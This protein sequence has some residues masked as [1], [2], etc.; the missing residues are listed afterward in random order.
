MKAR[1]AGLAVCLAVFLPGLALRAQEPPE[2]RI[3]AAFFRSLPAYRVLLTES[4]AADS[5]EAVF[6]IAGAEHNRT[7]VLLH[8]LNSTSAG[9]TALARDLAADFRVILIDLPGYG[10]SFTHKPISYDYEHM[11][12]RLLTILRAADGL[13]GAL[14]VGHSTGGALAWHLDLTEECRPAGLVLI[15]AVTVSFKLPPVTDL[16]FLVAAGYDT[17]GPFFNLIGNPIIMDLV[18]H[19]SSADITRPLPENRDDVEPMF[20]TPARIRVNRMWARQMLKPRVVSTWEPRLAEIDSPA[21]LIWGGRDG[22]L[23]QDVMTRA[24]AAIPGARGGVIDKAGHSPQRSHPDRVAALIR[25]F[26]AGL[27]LADRPRSL[28]PDAVPADPIALAEPRPE[29]RGLM[30]HAT[31]SL[32]GVAASAFLASATFRLKW[33]YYSTEYPSQSGSA[34]LF[35]EAGGKTKD[36]TLTL[37]AQVELVW[38]KWGGVRV[39]GGWEVAGYGHPSLLRIGYVP[40]YVPWLCLGAAWRGV[41]GKPAFFATIELAPKLYR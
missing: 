10:D 27:P 39:E 12:A 35:I 23:R 1:P 17:A 13:E 20:T 30:V 24:L 18:S 31:S 34:G 16:A 40:S 15:D 11:T 25:E 22:V 29:S 7:I 4:P 6:R 2:P 21:L 19:G 8:G 28:G 3:A 5:F 41:E 36:P 9:Y 26:A 37:G 33:G 38:E 14:L 32:T